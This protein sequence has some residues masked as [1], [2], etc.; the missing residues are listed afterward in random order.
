LRNPYGYDDFDGMLD[1]VEQVGGSLGDLDT[2]AK[3]ARLHRQRLNQAAPFVRTG[4]PSFGKG[5][6]GN[7]VLVTQGQPPT[8]IANWVADDESEA[9]TIMVTLFPTVDF[10]GTLPLNMIQTGAPRSR[11]F[12][13]IR[14]GSRATPAV[15]RVDMAKG[16]QFPVSASFVAVNVGLDYVN[17]STVQMALGGWLSAFTGQHVTPVKRTIYIDSLAAAGTSTF[18]VPTFATQLL[19]PQRTPLSNQFTLDFYDNVNNLIFS[20]QGGAGTTSFMTAPLDLPD[21][22]YS[23]TL[24]NDGASSLTVRIPFAL[25]F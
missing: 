12:A 6:S 13:E 11:P 1:D 8:A 21:D 5:T 17:S 23:C 20:V 10:V 19:P 22:A 18:L 2:Q 24:T 9:T 16:C 7:T 25:G 14:W 15:A 4:P 3:L